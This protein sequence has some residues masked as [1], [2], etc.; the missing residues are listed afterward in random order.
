MVKTI[1]TSSRGMVCRVRASQGE[2]SRMGS[3]FLFRFVS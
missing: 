2:E 1:G 3:L